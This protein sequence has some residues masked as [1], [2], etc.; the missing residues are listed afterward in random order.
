[1][2]KIMTLIA[3]SIVMSACMHKAETLPSTN[4]EW[5]RMLLGSYG[6]ADND[7]IRL[8]E[9][10][11]ETGEARMV[12]G[13]RGVADPSFVEIASDGR[14][15]YAVSEEDDSTAALVAAEIVTDGDSINMRIINS[16]TTDGTAP[17]HVKIIENRGKVFTSNY[18]GGSFTQFSIDKQTGALLPEK[19]VRHFDSKSHIHC[20]ETTP[21]M[22]Y[23]VVDD[24]GMDKVMLFDIDDEELWAVENDVEK[25]SGPRHI[26]FGPDG[27]FAYL[28]N[29]LSGTVTVFRYTGKPQ[30]E[31]VQYAACDSVGGHGSADIH[32]SNDGRFLY[33]SNR[34]KE[35]G[36][37][38]FSI[39]RESG[40]ITKVGYH[41]TGIHPRN[42]AL[43]PNGKYLLCACR[44]SNCI[45]IF[46]RDAET[47]M[48]HDTGKKIEMSKPTCVKFL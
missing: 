36:I 37:S 42:F 48:L 7:G 17:C 2:K 18:N 24:L 13:L 27:R 33:A 12:C 6:P 11:Q 9:F 34:L 40:K 43:S 44:G 22:A 46:T 39:D 5:V 29:E 30:M 3:T 28:I 35:D 10:N 23:Y 25:G 14:H 20:V 26:T 32:I 16:Q 8:Y 31:I 19:R 1:M 47:G 38:I 45:E 41:L 21:D 15:F 4:N